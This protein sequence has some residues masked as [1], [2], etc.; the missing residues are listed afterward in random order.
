MLGSGFGSLMGGS[1]KAARTGDQI[2]AQVVAL[3][4]LITQANMAAESF[5]NIEI[6]MQQIAQMLQQIQDPS[7]QMLSMQFQMLQQN[8]DTTQKAIQSPLTQALTV[9]QEIDNLTNKIQN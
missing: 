1:M 5:N 2:D 7:L 3:R 8:V 9:A 4:G 6:Q